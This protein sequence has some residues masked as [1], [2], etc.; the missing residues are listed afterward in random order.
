[1]AI[2]IYIY[3]YMSLDLLLHFSLHLVPMEHS[4]RR[5]VDT[6]SISGTDPPVSTHTIPSP[7]LICSNECLCQ[8]SYGGVCRTLGS[9]H[10]LP[11]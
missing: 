5:A 11:G 9:I 3:I 4:Q 8:Y 7:W 10:L 2:H 1:M 6:G